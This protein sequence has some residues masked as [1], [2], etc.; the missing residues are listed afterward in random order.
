MDLKARKVVAWECVRTKPDPT[1]G[2]KTD[3]LVRRL[4]DL[5]RGVST[6]LEQHKGVVAIE[7]MTPSSYAGKSS[8]STVGLLMSSYGAIIGCLRGRKPV[9]L[10]PHIVKAR[11]VGRKDSS[12]AETWLHTSKHFTSFPPSP[13]SKA[14]REA[15]EDATAVGLAAMPELQ[16]FL[17]LGDP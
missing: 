14:A 5:S 12:K 15:V 9:A 13:K 2:R 16:Q 10:M 1:A 4:T 6:F 17:A 11:V 3:D 7:A 8:L